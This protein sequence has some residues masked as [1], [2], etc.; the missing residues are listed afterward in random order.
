MT[1]STMTYIEELI[2]RHNEEPMTDKKV[3]EVLN[4]NDSLIFVWWDD[5]NPIHVDYNDFDD[6][7]K[8]AWNKV[9]EFL[10]KL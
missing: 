10:V 8:S 2:E 6:E 3:L 7:M 9:S 1:K 4:V 5:E